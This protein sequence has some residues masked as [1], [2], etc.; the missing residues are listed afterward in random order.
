VTA[1]V[2]GIH[3]GIDTHANRPAANT[4]PDGSLYSCSTHSL[5]YKSNF[6]GN[7]WATWAT[8]GAGGGGI[9]RSTLGTT[10]AGA[11]F[12]TTRGVYIKKVTMATAGLVGS[13]HAF[14]KGNAAN[15]TAIGVGILSDN[16]GAPLSIIAVN[17][18]IMVESTS[19]PTVSLG[20]STTVRDVSVPIGRWLA[21]ADYWLAVAIHAAAGSRIQLA[22]NAGSGT[23]RKF[24]GVSPVISDESFNTY[25]ASDTNDYSIYADVLR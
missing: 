12:A 5:I 16:S 22:F 13:I 8:L 20:M 25:G 3:L 14:V 1:T 19:D 11:S 18:P 23:D 24:T 10:S 15:G 21:A 17:G 9:T 7:S 6:G 2:A 4:V